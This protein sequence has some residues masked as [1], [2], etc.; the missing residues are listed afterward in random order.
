MG[1]EDTSR[2]KWARDYEPTPDE[3][4]VRNAAMAGERCIFDKPTTINAEFLRI[5]MLGVRSD[6]PVAPIGVII[7]GEKPGDEDTPR[8]LTIEGPL[9][10]TDARA[11]DGRALPALYIRNAHFTDPVALTGTHLKHLNFGGARGLS[12]MAEYLQVDCDVWLGGARCRGDMHFGGARIGGQFFAD[13]ARFE[14]EGGHALDLQGASVKG[15]V[16]L[17]NAIAKGCVHAVGLESDFQFSANG[18]QFENENG[19][20]LDL[21]GASVKGGVFLHNAIAKGCVHASGL[22]TDSQFSAN[23]A[24]FENE[25]DVAL[26]LQAASVKGGVF[27][28]RSKNGP[29]TFK[30]TVE[31][32]TSLLDKFNAEEAQFDG[33]STGVAIRLLRARILNDAWLDGASVNGN[34]DAVACTVGGELRLDYIKPGDGEAPLE[35]D[36]SNAQIDGVLTT[37][38]LG[39]NA[40]GDSPAEF[41][42]RGAHIAR[43]LDRLPN[44]SDKNGPDGWADKVLFDRTT[45]GSIAINRDDGKAS[46]A[47]AVA[48]RRIN[49]LLR[50]YP[51]GKPPKGAFNPQPFE[52]LAKTLRAQGEGEAANRVSARRRRFERKCSDKVVSEALSFLLDFTSRYGYAPGRIIAFF[53]AYWLFG[54]LA[55]LIHDAS[56]KGQNGQG[57]F[58]P[59]LTVGQP[60]SNFE[61]FIYALD[62]ITPFVEFGQAENYRLVPHCPGWPGLFLQERAW[63]QWLEWVQG[64]YSVFGYI[65][66]SILVLTL[67]GV[68]RR[69]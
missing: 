30:G 18:A 17:D 9:D 6:W 7:E 21:Q 52:Q 2:F 33:G 34:V 62:L 22:T 13:G 25:G 53:V 68:L 35:I 55:A 23:G 46:D 12:V 29:A 63:C 65:L 39:R 54:G 15:G 45:Y 49:W 41:D 57:G 20:A 1:T 66:F 36:L 42:L 11:A 67:T 24:Q 4:K 44:A 28:R 3:E 19:N 64:G 10:L 50:E 32:N 69:D 37:K 47:A 40:D 48:E 51:G 56:F 16:F 27:L 26:D 59:E 14:N 38:G 5:L 58:E 60:T 43:I 31:L 61:P 8:L